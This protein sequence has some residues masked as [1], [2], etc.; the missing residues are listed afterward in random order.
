MK[1]FIPYII[2]FVCLLAGVSYFL[3][4]YSPS[5]MEKKEADFAVPNVGDITKVKLSDVNGNTMVL[6]RKEKTWIVNGKY[7]VNDVAR[8]L[9]FT[10]IQKVE[11]NYPTPANGEAGDVDPAQ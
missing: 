9:L 5:T 6:T 11:T 2:V 7:E 4:Q 3:Y 10:A 8:D 1:K